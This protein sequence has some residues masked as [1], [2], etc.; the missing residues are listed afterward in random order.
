M[1]GWMVTWRSVKIE[2]ADLM[3]P[4]T[5]PL[6][7]L[8]HVGGGGHEAHARVASPWDCGRLAS[9]TAADGVPAAPANAEN[10]RVA[11][12]E[13]TAK[14]R[15]A[16]KV[17]MRGVRWA[18]KGLVEREVVESGWRE[19]EVL[20]VQKSWS[21]EFYITETNRV[22]LLPPKFSQKHRC[23]TCFLN[24]TRRV[25]TYRES[26]GK[27][28]SASYLTKAGKVRSGTIDEP[29]KRGCF[30]ENRK[31]PQDRLNREN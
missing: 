11:M 4:P 2:T 18:L 31:L 3:L 17:V 6:S 22:V 15:I 10:A 26:F 16:I 30:D 5:T 24:H 27:V 29:M 14:E 19:L 9:G 28:F 12:K 8:L 23:V 20:A 25:Q 21:F 1:W 13:R 7:Q